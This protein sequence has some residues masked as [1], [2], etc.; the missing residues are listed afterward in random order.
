M[1]KLQKEI[2]N[3]F[4][5]LEYAW[6]S[7]MK[8]E[9]R[10]Q[11]VAGKGSLGGRGTCLSHGRRSRRSPKSGGWRRL[12]RVAQT[13]LFQTFYI[14]KI[15]MPLIPNKEGPWCYYECWLKRD[16]RSDMQTCERYRSDLLNSHA[17][18][19]T[20]PAIHACFHDFF[21]AAA[22]RAFAA[23]FRLLLI[24]T[25]ARKDPTTADP[26]SVRMTGMRI[27]H[28]RGGKKLC[29]GWPSS[30]KGCRGELK[31]LLSVNGLSTYHEE[32]P[33]SVVEEDGRSCDQGR[34]ANQLVEL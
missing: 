19:Q 20:F 23:F 8:G 9:R 21:F 15:R 11:M 16:S 32:C 26:R 33:Y 25:M 31:R 30:T 1:R 12:S 34:H 24:M 28:T 17:T 4:T 29:K 18:L 27:A 14:R 5:T 2:V 13:S 3:A 6:K 10:G 7:K 22:A